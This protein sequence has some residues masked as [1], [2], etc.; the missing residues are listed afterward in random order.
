LRTLRLRSTTL[1]TLRRLRSSTTL[2][3]LRNLWR[4]LRTLLG[5]DG[6]GLGPCLL[7]AGLGHF[8][9]RRQ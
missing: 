4:R 5:M 3:R 7:I 9:I 1:R 6:L 2:R 8:P